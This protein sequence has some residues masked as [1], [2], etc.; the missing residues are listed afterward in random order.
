[1]NIPTTL[2]AMPATVI[3]DTPRTKITSISSPGVRH[4][5]TNG[6]DDDDDAPSDRFRALGMRCCRVRPASGAEPPPTPCLGI[7]LGPAMGVW[8]QA[9]SGSWSD[10]CWLA[11]GFQAW[12][13][14]GGHAMLYVALVAR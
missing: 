1:M 13:G 14:R 10:P 2:C 7:R 8:D 6:N 11:L 5:G 4:G 3:Y 9:G 12:G